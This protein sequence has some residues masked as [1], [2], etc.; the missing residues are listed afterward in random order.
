MAIK[1]RSINEKTGYTDYSHLDSN[2]NNSNP[3]QPSHLANLPT[4]FNL[5]S[6]SLEDCDQAVYSEFNDRFIIAENTMPI[7][8]LDAELSALKDQNYKQYDKT[9]D[10]LNG[11]FLTM[12]RKE[13]IPKYRTNPTTKKVVAAIPVQKAN[14]V[15][16]EEYI[17]DGPLCYD[18]IYD[19][20]FITNFRE[21]TNKFEEQFRN[22]F[23]NRRSII[24]I[25]NERFSIGPVNYD[26]FSSVELVNRE[27]IEQ[28]T[29]YVSTYELKFECFIRDL[30]NMQKRERPNKF[31][32]SFDVQDDKGNT[33][34]I[35][36]VEQFDFNA[37]QAVNND[38][39]KLV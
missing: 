29:L 35:T 22:Y 32:L 24:I 14:G 23:R 9:K 2:E 38:P 36:T 21:Y 28:R 37:K 31:F 39:N 1:K 12:Y 4:N 3:N 7:V 15:V 27:S 10:Y 19:F 30:S 20:K 25:N 11:P 26:T 33:Q 6:I 18:L 17:Y 13:S 5:K 34:N 16:F 8:L